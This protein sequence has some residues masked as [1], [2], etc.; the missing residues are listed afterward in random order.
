MSDEP[1]PEG[2]VRELCDYCKGKRVIVKHYSSYSCP[3]C[4][5]AGYVLVKKEGA[6]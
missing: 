1:T 3:K 4:R 2:W 6:T 5:E